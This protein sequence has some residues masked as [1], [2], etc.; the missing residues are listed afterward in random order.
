MTDAQ[1]AVDGLRRL[2]SIFEL[3]PSS[4][5]V[6][7][8][9]AIVA[10][11][12]RAPWLPPDIAPEWRAKERMRKLTQSVRLCEDCAINMREAL[13]SATCA[14]VDLSRHLRI[15]AQAERLS[16]WRPWR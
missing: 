9:F 15:A 8:A 11:R 5:Q 7:V 14:T 4:A 1:G 10:Q 16:V 2:R 12:T 6:A 3:M 13:S